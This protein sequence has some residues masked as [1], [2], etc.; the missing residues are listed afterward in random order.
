MIDGDLSFILKLHNI[1]L[2][3]LLYDVLLT[4][5]IVK[6]PRFLCSLHHYATMHFNSTPIQSFL[7]SSGTNPFASITEW[8]QIEGQTVQDQYEECGLHLKQNTE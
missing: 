8:I 1:S 3:Q 2:H 5:L 6:I 7:M 4:E